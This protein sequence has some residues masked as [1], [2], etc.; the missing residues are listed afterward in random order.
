MGG[1]SEVSLDDGLAGV[2]HAL[3]GLDSAYVLFKADWCGDCRRSLGAV[4]EVV[5]AAGGTLLVVD[6]AK[7]SPSWKTS[8]HPLRKDPRFQLAGVPTLVLW[9][10]GVVAA[11]LTSEL[12]D[13]PTT[14]AAGQAAAAFI[15][16]HPA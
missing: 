8:D 1:L 2:E 14:E 5:A 11:K 3:G 6:V 4:K 13:A 16:G 10:G 9:K 15:K 12:E 7:Q